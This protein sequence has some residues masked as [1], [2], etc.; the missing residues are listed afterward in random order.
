M[1]KKIFLLIAVLSILLSSCDK[2]VVFKE[3]KGEFSGYQ[4]KASDKVI[5]NADIEDASQSY[6]MIINFRHVYGFQFKDLGFSMKIESPDGSTVSNLYSINVIG[7]DN[8]F[9]SN[10]SGDYCDLEKIIEGS[11]K[12]KSAGKYKFT[13]EH[14]MKHDPIPLVMDIGLIIKKIP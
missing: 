7:D 8:E 11:Y 6:E 14:T 5:F 1:K 12:F 3:F 13:I 2:N 10:C 4:W 9:K